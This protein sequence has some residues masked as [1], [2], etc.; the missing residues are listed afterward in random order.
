MKKKK[1]VKILLVLSVVGYVISIMNNVRKLI[2]DDVE[3]DINDDT[4]VPLGI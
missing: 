3:L 2:S 1:I 4:D